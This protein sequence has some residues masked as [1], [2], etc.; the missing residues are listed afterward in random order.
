[1]Q[2]LAELAAHLHAARRST[3]AARARLHAYLLVETERRL[4]EMIARGL[5]PLV[6]GHR[7][8]W[9][10]HTGLKYERLLDLVQAAQGRAAALE[11]AL[12]AACLRSWPET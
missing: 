4:D 11:Q 12:V 8:W 10:A 6:V 3:T 2:E 1:M 9:E 7:P 5:D